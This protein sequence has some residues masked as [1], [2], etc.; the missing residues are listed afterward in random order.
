MIPGGA[1]KRELRQSDSHIAVSTSASGKCNQN[2]V[3][4]R[5]PDI[6]TGPGRGD[7]QIDQAGIEII[8]WLRFRF[9]P[10]DL[11]QQYSPEYLFSCFASPWK[12]L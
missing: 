7:P 5:P 6:L 4:V 10:I 2:I 1:G 8:A 9:R 12:L 3:N 11:A